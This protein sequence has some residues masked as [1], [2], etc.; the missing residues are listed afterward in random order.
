MANSYKKRQNLRFVF[1]SSS[2]VFERLINSVVF[3]NDYNNTKQLLQSSQVKSIKASKNGPRLLK[4]CGFCS[5][6]FQLTLYHMCFKCCWR[7]TSK[8][9]AH[10]NYMLICSFHSLSIQQKKRRIIDVNNKIFHITTGRE[11]KIRNIAGFCSFHLIMLI[12]RKMFSY[13]N[14]FFIYC[15]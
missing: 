14:V 8:Q 2:L 6:S 12:K 13:K 1:V 9:I 7:I 5:F 10:N 4:L 3:F 15:L 11:S